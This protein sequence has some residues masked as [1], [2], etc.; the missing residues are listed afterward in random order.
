VTDLDAQRA[1]RII[2]HL[3]LVGAEEDQIAGL[4]AGALDD[5]L[6]RNGVQ[7]LDDRRLQAGLVQLRDIV[8]LD[9]GEAAA[10]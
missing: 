9:V 8:D 2:D 1:Q 4:C 10:P 6:Q 5:G 7:I 3:A